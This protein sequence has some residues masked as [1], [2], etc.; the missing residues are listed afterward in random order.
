MRFYDSR[1]KQILFYTLKG[2]FYG[3]VLFSMPSSLALKYL[4]GR[5]IDK[6]GEHLGLPKS[7]AAPVNTYGTSECVPQVFNVSAGSLC[8]FTQIRNDAIDTMIPLL[9]FVLFTGVIGG[10]MIGMLF[11]YM[12]TSN[13]SVFDSSS[14]PTQPSPAKES[15]TTA[16]SYGTIA[17]TNTQSVIL[18]QDLD[19]PVEHGSLVV[20]V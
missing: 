9:N 3:A 7:L 10:A 11:G 20:T 4:T 2:M 17:E 19:D 14:Q 8:A 1:N 5:T 15:T 13:M 6:A 12:S 18:D 16:K